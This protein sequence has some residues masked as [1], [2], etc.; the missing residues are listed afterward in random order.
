MIAA[1]GS[2]LAPKVGGFV[3]TRVLAHLRC[4]GEQS[5]CAESSRRTMSSHPPRNS[6]ALPTHAP[7]A[8][9]T[10]A[11]FS[12]LKLTPPHGP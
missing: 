9:P 12:I 5:A 1:K 7:E 3:G 6:V 10:T 11:K 2:I 4:V 8:S